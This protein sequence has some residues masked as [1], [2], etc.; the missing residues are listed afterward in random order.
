M[1]NSNSN[2]DYDSNAKLDFSCTNRLNQCFKE[3]SLKANKKAAFVTFITGG[4]PILCDTV[5]IMHCMVKNGVDIIELGVPFSD[6]MADGPVIQRSSQRAVEAGISLMHILDI[7][8]KFRV[9]NTYTPIVLMGYAN[10]IQHYQQKFGI[11]TLALH[12]QHAGVDAILLVDMPP[13][14]DKCRTIFE[15]HQIYSIYL[16]A[17]TT[18]QHRIDYIQ[19]N[20]KGYIYYVA[21]KGVTGSQSLDTQ[22]IAYNVKELKEKLT[23]PIAVGFGIDSPKK[24]YDVAQYADAIIMGSHIIQLL[25]NTPKDEQIDVLGQFIQNVNN[26]LI[27]KNKI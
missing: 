9:N 26:M 15:T 11:D 19:K 16:I 14:Y 6:P 23:L 12:M 18:P 4:D 5:D 25:E 2:D 27:Q 7:V 22:S 8:K 3:R 17:P 24:A 21:V 13:E 10:I 1:P 20:A